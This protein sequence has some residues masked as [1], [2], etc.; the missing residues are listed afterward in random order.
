MKPYQVHWLALREA[1]DW[2][3]AHPDL[4]P[5]DARI[6]TWFPWEVRLAA[7]RTTIL[8][9]RSMAYTEFELNRIEETIRQYGVTHVLWGS[10]D[11]AP[12]ADP[13]VRGPQLE[14]L[15]IASGLVKPLV[16]YESPGSLP[17]PVRLYRLTGGSR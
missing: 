13:E 8:L 14:Q 10:F 9:P 4:V 5:A 7:D 11:P 15:R 12:F 2:I 17:Y 16:I 3:K 6:M 1:G